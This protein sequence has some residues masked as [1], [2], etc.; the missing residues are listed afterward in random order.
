MLTVTM[1]RAN[2]VTTALQSE[3]VTFSIAQTTLLLIINQSI[4]PRTLLGPFQKIRSMIHVRTELSKN[5]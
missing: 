2:A 4:H 3:T 5:S 1:Y